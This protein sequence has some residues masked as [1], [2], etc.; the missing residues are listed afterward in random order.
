[1]LRSVP[2]STSVSFA[3]AEIVVVSFSKTVVMSS[4]ASGLSFLPTI[5]AS[6]DALSE[7]PSPSFT[8]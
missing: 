2:W 4:V 8:V 1:M 5:V 7:P 6:I 3:R